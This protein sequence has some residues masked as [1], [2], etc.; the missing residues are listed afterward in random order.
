MVDAIYQ[1][2]EL[3]KKRSTIISDLNLDEDFYLTTIHR[4]ENTDD[5]KKLVNIVDALTQIENTTV[6]PVHPRT[7][8]KLREYNLLNKIKKNGNIRLIKPVGYLDFLMLLSKAKLVLTDSGGV[9][10]EAFLLKTPCITLRENTE[11]VE[12]VE[13][14]WNVLVGAQR[15]KIIN[16][17]KETKR[18]GVI[19]SPFGDGKASRRIIDVIEENV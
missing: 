4:A 17:L 8:K 13:L 9:Q 7:K 6:F 19:Q 18:P 3:A 15:E 14:G 10:K 12:T 1:N 11:W 16:A 5:R 2:L